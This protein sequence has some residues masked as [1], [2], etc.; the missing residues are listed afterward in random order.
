MKK[1]FSKK[2]KKM[3]GIDDLESSIDIVEL[4]KRYTNLKKA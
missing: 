3:A 1:Y 4:V 2:L